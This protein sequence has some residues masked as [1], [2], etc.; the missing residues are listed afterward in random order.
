MRDTFWDRLEATCTTYPA[1]MTPSVCLRMKNSSHA[2]HY[3]QFYCD[4]ET[5][6]TE[7]RGEQDPVAL[8]SIVTRIQPIWLVAY[9]DGAGSTAD[10][11]TL[12]QLVCTT[13]GMPE[14][15]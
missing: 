10:Y 6:L 12:W 13:K 8:S 5:I 15:A 9:A 3:Q 14:F 7:Y 2:E 11:D 4:A 1:I